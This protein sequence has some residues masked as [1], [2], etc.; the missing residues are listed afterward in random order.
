M[1]YLLIRIFSFRMFRK[2][3]HKVAQ[4]G[5]DM[6]IAAHELKQQNVMYWVKS[7]AATCVSWS[8]RFTIINCI[9]LAFCP[10][11][12]NHFMLYAR[13]SIMG[14]ILLVSPTPGGAGFAEGGFINFLGEFITNPALTAT[15]ALLWR[16]LS[17]YSYYFIGAI[18]LP[19]WVRRVFKKENS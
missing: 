14:I 15:L 6:V 7:F 13:Q 5:S 18:V 17:T 4:T 3:R 9:I 10:S 11:D 19:I 2:W 8:A 12:F 1:K 16:M